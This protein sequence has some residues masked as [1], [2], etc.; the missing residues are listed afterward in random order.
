MVDTSRSRNRNDTNSSPPPLCDRFCNS[1]RAIHHFAIDPSC[2][3]RYSLS[4]FDRACR[5]ILKSPHFRPVTTSTSSYRKD[6]GRFLS[7]S[8]SL[9]LCYTRKVSRLRNERNTRFD[10]RII[11]RNS[12]IFTTFALSCIIS[13]CMDLFKHWLRYTYVQ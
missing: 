8:L 12:C 4:L 1:S 9:C 13:S 11:G 7:L 2:N 5:A 3:H 10:R 6:S